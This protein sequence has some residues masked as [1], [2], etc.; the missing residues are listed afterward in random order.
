MITEKIDEIIDRRIGRNAYAGKGHLDCVKAQKAF[1]LKL[2]ERVE[3]YRTFRQTV[4]KQIEDGAGEY[5]AM[6]V[7]DPSFEE[8]VRMADP[9]R[10]LSGLNAALAECDRLITRFSR[11]TVN[12]SVIGL[13]RQGKSTLLQSITQLP[14][15]IIPAA[16]GSDCTGAKSVISNAK[17]KT[18]A[19]VTFYSEREL[20][21]QLQRYL[22]K[23]ESGIVLG[24]LADLKRISLVEIKT[25][26]T[27]KSSFLSHFK[28][29]MEHYGEYCG[30]LGSVITVHDEERIRDYVAQYGVDERKTYLYLAVKEVR[31]YT[32]FHYADAGKITLVDTIGIGDTSLGIEDKMMATLVN[33]SDAAIL[34]RRPEEKGDALREWDNRL[35][36]LIKKNMQGQELDKWLFYVLN[37][38]K[39]NERTSAGMFAQLQEHIKSGSLQVAKLIEVDC[40]NPEAVEKDLVLVILD[41]LTKNLETIDAGMLKKANDSFE[42]LYLD[43][44]DLRGKIGSVLDNR[45]RKIMNTGGLFDKLFKGLPLFS[46]LRE[47]EKSYRAH[48]EEQCMAIKEDVLKVLR[49]IACLCPDKEEVLMKLGGGTIDAQPNVVYNHYADHLRAEIADRFEIVTNQTLVELQEKVKTDIIDILYSQDGGRLGGIPLLKPVNAG[50]KLEWLREFIEEKLDN[51]P[52]VKDAFS[53]ILDYRLNIEGLLEYKVNCSLE[54]LD[55]VSK[56]FCNIDPRGLSDEETADRI[57][58]SFLYAIDTVADDMVG[59]VADMLVI[60]NNSFFA[61]I[62]KFR[63]KIAYSDEGNEE[64]KEFYRD[65]C[66]AVWKEEFGRQISTQAALGAWTNF[67]SEIA[68]LCDRS[69]FNIKIA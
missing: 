48:K 14:D 47:L 13:A 62:R 32:E 63:E 34:I 59:S 60:P 55:P 31:I 36:D 65:N 1:F 4:L 23:L 3:S 5:Y 11:D 25:D 38:Y 39:G 46:R 45:F 49:G 20:M 18:Y 29:Y 40:K 61:R 21:E 43:F 6:S 44:Y 68:S 12:I 10:F 54:Y 67:D 24:S 51:F 2:K 52:S 30:L 22:D 27:A 56:K 28:K 69:K 19:E 66:A 50:D 26:M 15:S 17:G 37:R 35:Y 53:Y 8:K 16:S 33:D 41:T 9:D 64:L 57:A 42:R 58:Q 7:E